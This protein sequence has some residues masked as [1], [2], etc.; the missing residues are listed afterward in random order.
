MK[1]GRVDRILPTPNGKVRNV[2]FGGADF[3]TL[4]ATCGDKVYK[5]KLQAKGAPRIHGYRS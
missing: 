3:S 4:Y 1:P 2:V 5:R